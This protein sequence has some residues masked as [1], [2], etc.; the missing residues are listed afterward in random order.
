MFHSSCALNRS[1][2][3]RRI[4]GEIVNHLRYADDLCLI[5]ISSAGMQKLLNVCSSYATEDSLSYN[6]NKSYSLCFKATTIKFERPTLYFGQMSSPNVIDCRYLAITIYAKNCDL[7]LIRQKRRFYANTNMLLRK[8]VPC[9]PDVKCYLLVF[10]SFFR[11]KLPIVVVRDVC[12]SVCLSVRPSVE[13]I[14]F[15]GNSL[16]NRPIEL[17]IRLNVRQGVMHVRKA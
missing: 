3:G 10:F 5:C 11:K 7:D 17:K 12:P 1:N 14:S 13:I 6:A 15:C 9:S 2:I 16:F 8:F 4:G